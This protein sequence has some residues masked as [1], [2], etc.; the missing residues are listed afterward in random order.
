MSVNIAYIQAVTKNYS[1]E[2]LTVIQT[3]VSLFRVFWGLTY[4]PYA[5]N[6]IKSIQVSLFV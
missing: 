5:Y 1:S 4:I 3:A 2:V 6:L